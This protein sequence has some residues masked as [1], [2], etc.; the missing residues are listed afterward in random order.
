[1]TLAAHEAKP[2]LL[3]FE[4]DQKMICS[5]REENTELKKKVRQDSSL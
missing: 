4:D 2:S 3:S 5:L 1:M